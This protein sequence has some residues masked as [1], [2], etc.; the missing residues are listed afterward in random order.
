MKTLQ[1]RML[2]VWLVVTVCLGSVSALAQESSNEAGK[3]ATAPPRGDN[4][5]YRLATEGL[6]EGAVSRSVLAEG[7]RA[8]QRVT[9]VVPVTHLSPNQAIQT[10]SAFTNREVQVWAVVGRPKIVFMGA[11]QAVAHSMRFLKAIDVPDDE[12]IPERVVHIIEVK[13]TDAED[14]ASLLV[15]FLK[16]RDRVASTRRGRGSPRDE[17]LRTKLIPDARTNKI[18]VQTNRPQDLANIQML[19]RE[20]DVRPD[21]PKGPARHRTRIYRVQHVDPENLANFLSKLHRDTVIVPHSE[22]HSLV[23]QADPLEFEKI[24]SALERVDVDTSAEEGSPSEK[25]PAPED[26]K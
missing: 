6:Q 5:V 16:S 13:N 18:V 3:S 1:R 15:A 17:P 19:V 8:D 11:A 24:Q 2:A 20:L 12:H 14:L 10:L 21:G 23:I 22:T 26:K 25:K 9:V 7:V 4:P